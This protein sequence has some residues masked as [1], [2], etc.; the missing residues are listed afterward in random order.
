MAYTLSLTI[1]VYL[2]SFSCCCLPNLRNLQ[3]SPKF[4]L[5]A[6]QGHPRS[7]IL[8]TVTISSCCHCDNKQTEWTRRTHNLITE[9]AASKIHKQLLQATG[10][11]LTHKMEDF[12]QKQTSGGHAEAHADNMVV[13]EINLHLLIN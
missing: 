6:V 1:W 2:H 4:K 7:S 13:S 8:L 11:K 3:N 9:K 10:Q 5:I 12:R